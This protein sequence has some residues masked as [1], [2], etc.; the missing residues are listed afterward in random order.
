MN[1]S[2]GKDV[3]WGTC[4]D[5]FPAVCQKLINITISPIFTNDVI[6]FFCYLSSISGK[7]VE[8]LGVW[9]SGTGLGLGF[10]LLVSLA[11]PFKVRWL[12]S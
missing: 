5:N 8:L 12:G 3:T 6:I 11:L 9:A 4:V 7:S 10:W 2:F 1:L